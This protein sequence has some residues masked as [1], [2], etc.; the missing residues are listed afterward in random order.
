M[1]NRMELIRIFSVAAQST[2]FRDA[3]TRLG[4]SPQTVTRGLSL[5]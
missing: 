4:T 1:L 2:T 5:I 3:A